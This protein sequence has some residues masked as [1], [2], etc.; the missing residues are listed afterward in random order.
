[1]LLSNHKA[2][3][4]AQH[5]K[6]KPLN[7][8]LEYEVVKRQKPRYNKTS[9][10]Y[11][12][13]KVEAD[14]MFPHGNKQGISIKNN[15]V[16]VLLVIVDVFSRY[17]WVYPMHNKSQTKAKFEE[18]LKQNVPKILITD[19]GSE[20]NNLSFQ[21]LMD[22]HKV[23]HYIQDT[24]ISDLQAKDIRHVPIAERFNQTLRGYIERALIMTEVPGRWIDFL[25][26]IVKQY[27]SAVH[28]TIKQ[29]PYD[30][31][32][33]NKKPL[34]DT[35][36]IERLPIGTI[37]RKKVY[38]KQFEKGNQRWSNELYEILGYDGVKYII[39][40]SDIVYL[41]RELLPSKIEFLPQNQ[42]PSEDEEEEPE[43]EPRPQ[44]QPEPE[45]RPQR[46]QRN[47]ILPARYRD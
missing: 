40:D 22:E 33:N 35:A 36:D 47:R 3:K 11:A 26:N 1:M 43:P 46:P 10:D 42:Q 2:E 25:P 23:F 39:D 27:N 44:Q 34:N 5:N 28:S 15:S 9:A 8:N 31:M 6:T 14:L 37:V 29:T 13:H 17:A 16:H 4:T 21:K 41:R 38:K 7:P 24:P 30:V 18:F 20:F 12:L 32:F 19:D 45:P